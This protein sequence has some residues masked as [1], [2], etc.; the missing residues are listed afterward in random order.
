MSDN[1]AERIAQAKEQLS[2]PE[3]L[4]C[5]G[6]PIVKASSCKVPWREDRKPSGS[7]YDGGKRFKDFGT[8]EDFDAIDLVGKITGCS[9]RDAIETFLQMAGTSAVAD[10]ANVSP[11]KATGVNSRPNLSAFGTGSFEVVE[12]VAISRKINPR[13]VAI[14]GE[15]GCL[16]FG[17]VCGYSAWVLTD[18]S[19]RCAEARR[20]DGKLFPAFTGKGVELAERKAHT[21]RGSQKNWPVGILPVL[22]YRNKF[23]IIALVEGGPDFFSAL[24][25]A[26]LQNRM[27]IQPVAILGRG[28]AKHGF[29]PDSLELFRGRR[30]RIYP[31]VDSDGGGLDQAVIW[32]RQL[33]RLECE[34]DLFSLDG[35]QKIDG[36]P[37]KDLNDAAEI[38][39]DQAHEL[40]ELFP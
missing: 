16:R 30:V 22:E 14:A 13:A 32:A 37:I 10:S 40:G 26:L 36:S 6:H 24:H 35:L 18:I 19:G 4:R 21:I 12:T 11:A 17:R 5:L 9:R 33:E 20:I 23:N 7:I 25:F 39:P 3:L 1:L 8:G 27:D 38:V 29:H 31:H 2:I 34:V 15:M 28:Q